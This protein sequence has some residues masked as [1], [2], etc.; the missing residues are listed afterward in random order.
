MVGTP[1]HRHTR[2]GRQTEKVLLAA[3][4]LSAGGQYVAIEAKPAASSAPVTP[5]PEA[6]QIKA[7]SKA[8]LMAGR[9]R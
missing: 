3:K 6:A 4:L 9:A 2:L 5:V 8:Q 7:P 1:H